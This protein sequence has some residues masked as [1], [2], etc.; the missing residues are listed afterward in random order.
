MQSKP[1]TSWQALR[2]SLW[3]VFQAAPQE[4]RN[5]VFLN[6]VTG[7]GP[8]IALF[9]GKEIIDEISRLLGQG[10]TDHA[11]SK[12]SEAIALILSQ[13]K[14]LWSIAAVVI[15]NLI[16]DSVDS[17]SMSLFASLRDR[18]QGYGQGK[19]LQKVA[20][21]DDIALFETPD[22]LN[23]LQLTDKGLQR[24][25]R[26]S[27]IVAATL[28]GIFIFIPSVGVSLS[29]AGWV[30][31]VL[32]I[33]SIPS[34]YIE[35]KHHKKSWRVEETQAGLTREMDIYAKVLTEEAYA[36]EVRLFSL[37]GVLLDRWRGLFGR[38][39][40]TMERVRRE[41]AIAV[42][43]WA[44]LGGIGAALPYVY[45][46]IGVLQGSFTLGDLALYTG[47][48]LQVRRSLYILIANTGD[49]YDVA[50]ATS[51]IFQLL[52]LEPQLRNGLQ[53]MVSTSAVRK[54]DRGIQLQEVSF[55]YPGSDRAILD[56]VNLAIQPG[57]M[58]ALVG[59]NGAGKTTLA[60]L[61][62]RLY[63][64]ERGGIYWNGQDLRSLELQQ[65][66]SRIAVVM[67]DYARFPA[68]L[69]ENV[70]WGYLPEL[71]RDEAIRTV[72]KEAGIDRVIAQ[73]SQEL[74]TPL[75]KQLENGIDLSG[76]Q[77]Q[78]IAIARALMRLSEAELLVFDEPTAALDPKNEHEIYRIFSAI[79]RGRMTVVVSHRLALAKIADRIIVLEGG[80]IIEEG[81][82]ETLMARRDRYYTMFSRQASS[83]L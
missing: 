55:T 42:M 22:L 58:V 36:K 71:H 39:F 59:E 28:M 13:P 10:A 8:S 27:F 16:V 61:L 30:P 75:G 1:L 11:L 45:V 53:P 52:D 2:R 81:S 78:R 35:M 17:V 76:G 26:L 14:L 38:M 3:M 66:R 63:D 54:S 33:S 64:P 15:L 67:Q 24:L 21:F 74:E 12:S 20:N 65:L 80:K 77:W 73:L 51:P 25:Q 34:I 31:F 57:E 48:I 82:H 29:I 69:R 40:G 46:V 70:G 19:V 50:L 44:L 6:L 41:G 62:C 4:L 47:I 49:I 7:T 72:L 79:A 5:L 43:L 32:I 37:Q 56:R 68:T 23:L 60:K 83:Y 9:L 18:V